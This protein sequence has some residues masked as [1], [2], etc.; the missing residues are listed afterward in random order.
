MI[1]SPPSAAPSS[2][3]TI[4]STVV[5][6]HGVPSGASG[7]PRFPGGTLKMQVPFFQRLGLDLSDWYLATINLSIAPHRYEPHSPRYHFRQV[8]WH[9][10][11]PAED[12]SFYDC[13]LDEWEGLIYYPHPE[14]KP[15]HHQPEDVLEVIMK[16]WLPDLNYGAKV[17]LSVDPSQVRLESAISPDTD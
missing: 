17:S 10:T 7:D 6:G 12:F 15:E 5:R 8:Q 9:P 4:D 16:Q 2:W 14:T 1:E 11:E 3:P 13:R